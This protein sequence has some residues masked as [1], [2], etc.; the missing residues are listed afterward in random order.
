MLGTLGRPESPLSHDRR[1]TTVPRMKLRVRMALLCSLSAVAFLAACDNQKEDASADSATTKESKSSDKKETVDALLRAN[2][3]D[4]DT[5]KGA[6]A[7]AEKAAPKAAS[8]PAPG[9][10][11]AAA[12]AAAEE[13]QG[14]AGVRYAIEVTSKGSEPRSLLKYAFGE[15]E[16]R[17]LTMDIQTA[18]AL[19]VNGQPLQT[20]PPVQVT[21]TGTSTTLKQEGDL[22]T[23]ENL[24]ATLVPS[25]N[26]IPPEMVDQVKAQYALLQGLRLIETVNTKGEL[27]NVDVPSQQQ[28]QNQQVL[29]LLQL[30]QDTLSRSRVPLPTDAI[31][32][33]GTWTASAQ[34]ENGGVTIRD[35][36]KAKL[37]SL[38][39]T[40]A[41]IEI[42]IKQ[43]SPGGKL[44][45]PQLPP[46]ASV[47]LLGISGA[48][49]GQ[50]EIDTKTLQLTAKVKV[51]TSRDTKTRDPSQP[52][53][54]LETVETST[55]FEVRLR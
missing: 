22:A 19:T 30:L 11:G 41:I 2:G 7:T 46:G 26:G 29:V 51:K 35:E 21:I 10:D 25:V 54:I 40:K 27:L 17:N 55:Q 14:P 13:T 24:F 49:T 4:P 9:S 37:V 52:E 6:D 28:V 48:G 15:G 18:S 42:E 32:K 3:I 45:L 1:D 20:A 43:S 5:L 12:P 16:K 8:P 34:A 53:P 36:I 23:R 44:D 38:V 47:E 33:G 39:G 31:G 50:V